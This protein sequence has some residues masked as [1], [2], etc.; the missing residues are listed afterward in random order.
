MDAR[1]ICSAGYWEVIYKNK[2]VVQGETYVVASNIADEL[3]GIHHGPSECQ[4]VAD[5]IMLAE[6]IDSNGSPDHPL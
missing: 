4:E 1:I 2:L 6:E 3:N 5:A